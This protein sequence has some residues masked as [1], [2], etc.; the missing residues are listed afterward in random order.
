MSRI[1]YAC[2][3][4]LPTGVALT[5]FY[6]HK[7][8]SK[9]AVYTTEGSPFHFSSFPQHVINPRR[10]AVQSDSITLRI[11]T[12]KLPRGADGDRIGDEE[13]LARFTRGFFGGWAFCLEGMFFWAS[14]YKVTRVS[15]MS[16]GNDNLINRTRC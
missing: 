1:F 7:S 4:G 8:P 6:I 3:F 13:I 2:L 16:R 11:P 10:Y 12:S 5:Y 15:S 9:D 14:N